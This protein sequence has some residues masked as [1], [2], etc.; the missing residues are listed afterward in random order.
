MPKVSVIIPCYNQGQY[1]D[2]A[3]DSILN[4][5]YQ[6]FEIIIVDDGSTDKFTKEKLEN[7]HKP[8]TKVILTENRGVSAAR[9]TAIKNSSG[10]YILPV[11]GDDKIDCTYLEQALEIIENNN[12]LTIVYCDAEF[13]G[14]ET[15]ILQL[16]LFNI[17]KFLFS[18][19]IHVSGLFPR[20]A[21]DEIG[22]Y[23]E[24]MK[25]GLEDWDFWL[26]LIENGAN[27]YKISKPLLKY[28]K[29]PTSRQ[30]LLNTNLPRTIEINS[31][32]FDKHLS[33]Y[34]KVLGHP[35]TLYKNNRELEKKILRILH[36]KPYKLGNFLLKPIKFLFKRNS[37]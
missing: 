20:K 25:D 34:S 27:V 11:D 36:S 28:R 13:F 37:L 19:M 5:T 17:E 21:Y 10:E 26:S 24:N 16:P 23:D 31:Y 12:D 35:M 32:I 2:E 29:Y 22:G 3:V 8:K 7:Y 14:N 4:Q 33:F 30:T 9:N 1:I 15:G 18:N 6:D